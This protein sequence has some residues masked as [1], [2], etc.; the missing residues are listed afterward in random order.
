[1]KIRINVIEVGDVVAVISSFR[2][3]LGRVRL[4]V[5]PERAGLLAALQEVADAGAQD[6]RMDIDQLAASLDH[7]R[8]FGAADMAEVPEPAHVPQRLGVEVVKLVE[9][10]R[11]RTLV[12]VVAERCSGA[13]RLM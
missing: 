1:V 3:R 6:R 12:E 10:D 8:D 11:A 2:L 5:E 4:H 13:E 7:Q 9:Q